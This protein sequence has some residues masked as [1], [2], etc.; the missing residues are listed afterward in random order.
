[1]KHSW[2]RRLCLAGFLP[3]LPGAA[4][5]FLDSLF[6]LKYVKSPLS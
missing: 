1:M 3:V 6:N 4:V 5:V 2:L